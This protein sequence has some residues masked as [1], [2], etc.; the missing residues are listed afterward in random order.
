MYNLGPCLVQLHPEKS[1]TVPPAFAGATSHNPSFRIL[2]KR[3]FDFPGLLKD[4]TFLCRVSLRSWVPLEES[5]VSAC[6]VSRDTQGI[7][8]S[9]LDSNRCILHSHRIENS[10]R[11]RRA[12]SRDVSLEN[13]FEW[14]SFSLLDHRSTIGG[15]SKIDSFE[16]P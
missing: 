14:T 4:A 2:Q 15:E 12:N 16:K 1:V 6:V 7:G 10:V 13:Y 9:P 3:G 5:Y 8:F 11:W